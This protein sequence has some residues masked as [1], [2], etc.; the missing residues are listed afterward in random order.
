MKATIYT[1]GSSRGNPGPGGWGVVYYDDERVEEKGGNEKDTTNNRMEM[2]A[3]IEG[4][5][6]LREEVKEITICA[7]SEY[8]IKGA[9]DWMIGWKKNGWKTSAKKPVLNKDLWQEIDHLLLDLDFR[10]VKVHFKHVRGHA[11]I[12]LNERADVIATT[13]ADDEPTELF[14]GDKGKYGEFLGR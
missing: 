11:G 4:L 8:V 9:T 12:E 2:Q 14:I 13:F 3:L 1:D 5:L 10:Q 7:D 6:D